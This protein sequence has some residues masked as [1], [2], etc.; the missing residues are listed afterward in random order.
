[1]NIIHTERIL[2]NQDINIVHKRTF[3]RLDSDSAPGQIP[4]KKIIKH[5]K[6]N[7]CAEII[8]V[9]RLRTSNNTCVWFMVSKKQNG[10]CFT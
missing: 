8:M 5:K 1:M 3:T 6:D 9:R 10:M 2:V 7:Y 4:F